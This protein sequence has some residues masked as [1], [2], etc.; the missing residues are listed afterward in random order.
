MFLAARDGELPNC[1]QKLNC[2]G[3]PIHSTLAAFVLPMIILTLVSDVP[4]LA[5]LHAIGFVGAISL[6]L[7]STATSSSAGWRA[8]QRILTLVTF[9]VM[10][11]VEISLF[12]DKPQA[13]NF[14]SAI[15]GF[16]LILQ[17]LT[18]KE[19]EKVPKPGPAVLTKCYF[20]KSLKI[21]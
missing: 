11:S 6:H 20:Q 15:I 19:K 5:S 7:L 13:R 9:A 8:W 3:D 10:A 4:G 14:V 1:F 21:K 18:T 12:I 17:A 2:F 16:G